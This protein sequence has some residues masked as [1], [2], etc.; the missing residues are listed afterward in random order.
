MMKKA[1][2]IGSCVGLYFL[3][4]WGITWRLSFRATHSDPYQNCITIDEYLDQ[5]VKYHTREF[6][7]YYNQQ[8]LDRTKKL[9]AAGVEKAPIDRD[10]IFNPFSPHWD[11]RDFERFGWK[12]NTTLASLA[13]GVKSPVVTRSQLFKLIPPPNHT[14]MIQDFGRKEDKT[15]TCIDGRINSNPEFYSIGDFRRK[16]KNKTDFIDGKAFDQRHQLYRFYHFEGYILEPE[17]REWLYK[18]GGISSVYSWMF[19]SSFV[20]EI[21]DIRSYFIWDTFLNKD[22][23]QLYLWSKII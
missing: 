3:I 18:D 1:R 4:Y 10:Q 2:I 19:E 23:K 14:K 6:V 9:Q 21:E 5:A 13:P 7:T 12:N 8:Y 22:Q 20:P 11:F 15:P 16:H 17:T